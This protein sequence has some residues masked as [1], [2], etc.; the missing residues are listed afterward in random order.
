MP[1]LRNETKSKRPDNRRTAARERERERRR[2]NGH[3]LQISLLDIYCER[4]GAGRRRRA[5]CVSPISRKK[6]FK[7]P[8]HRRLVYYI[9][10]ST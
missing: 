4:G 6:T 7:M 10:S 8:L 1:Q 3:S 9:Y 2:K 5:L